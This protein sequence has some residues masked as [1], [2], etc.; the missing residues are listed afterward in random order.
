MDICPLTRLVRAA[1]FF[2]T[3]VVYVRRTGQKPLCNQSM[4]GRKA[5]TLLV[6]ACCL[7]AC[8]ILHYGGPF[9]NSKSLSD[10]HSQQHAP[11]SCGYACKSIGLHVLRDR[12]GVWV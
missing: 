10:V 5:W 3:A 4:E 11:G 6:F 1:V 7:A 12:N 2:L 8:R 9:V